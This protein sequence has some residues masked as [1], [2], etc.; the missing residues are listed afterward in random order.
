[1]NSTILKQLRRKLKTTTGSIIDEHTFHTDVQYIESLWQRIPIGS[2]DMPIIDIGQ[3]APLVFVP[4]LEH[5]E[6]VYARQI[7]ALS[8]TRRVILYR[9]QESRTHPIGLTERAEELRQV[10]DSLGLQR[11]DLLGHG[12]AAMVLLAFAARYP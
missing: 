4:I 3:G 8:S 9:R 2:L 10:L 6:F 7:R 12:D 1:M 11:V 5:L